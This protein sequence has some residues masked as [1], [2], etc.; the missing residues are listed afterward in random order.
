VRLELFALACHLASFLRTLALPDEVAEWSLTSS[1]EKLIKIGLRWCATAMFQPTKT[2]MSRSM[3]SE[4]LALR[5]LGG[6][7]LDRSLGSRSL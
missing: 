5:P 4:I 7:R 2:A 1:R 6:S 3:F